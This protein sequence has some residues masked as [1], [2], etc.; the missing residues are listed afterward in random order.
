MRGMKVPEWTYDADEAFCKD[1]S[2]KT[3]IFSVSTPGV[4]YIQNPE[5]SARTAR[6]MNEFCATLKSTNPSS[7]GFF[8]TIPSLVHMEHALRELR[9]AYENLG[10][11]GITLFTSY[12]GSNNYLGHDQFVPIW[13]ELDAR[14]AVVFVHPCDNG[15]N[16][17]LFNEQVAGPAFDWPHETGRTA[18]DLI[19]KGRMQQFPN[20]KI[21]LSHAGGTLP[22]LVRRATMLSMPEFGGVMGADEIYDGA[23]SFYFDTA[24]SGSQEVFPLIKGFA[25]KGHLLFGSDYPHACARQSK[26]HANFVDGYTMDE[27]DRKYIYYEA[28][29]SL[30]PRLRSAYEA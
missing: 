7:C 13:K 14:K 6:S 8:A 11:D 2:V 16:A 5:E 4:Y 9:Y 19:I 22:T 23:R 1:V 28:A 30:F 20:V 26:A 17:T 21:I 10:A 27:E 3:R 29:L 24:L 25:K 15:P 18:M 12:G